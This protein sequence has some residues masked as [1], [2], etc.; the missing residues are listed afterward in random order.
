MSTYILDACALIAFLTNEVGAEVVESILHDAA[1]GDTNIC[2]HKVNLL[3]VY[4]GDYRAHGKEAA[5][6]MLKIVKSLPITI[7][8]ELTDNVFLEAGRLKGTYKMSLA[9]AFALGE[10]SVLGGIIITADHHELDVVAQNE[11][12]DFKWFR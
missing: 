9:D 6:N 12:I 1:T 11:T 7:I 2:M 8:P 10:A 5:D 4:Y 3:E